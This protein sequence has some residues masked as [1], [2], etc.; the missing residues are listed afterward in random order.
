MPT[1]PIN[2]QGVSKKPLVSFIIPVYNLPSSMVIECLDSILMLSLD[3]QNC[4]IIVVDDGSDTSLLGALNA[5][6]DK[7]VYIRQSNQGAA[8]ARNM[9]L[10][11]AK[12][13]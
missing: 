4:E 1:E 2:T 13:E 6:L 10:C 5:Y 7:I 3:A 8:S 9:G 12:G 11:V